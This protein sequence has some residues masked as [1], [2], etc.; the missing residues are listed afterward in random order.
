MS[1]KHKYAMHFFLI[2][3][4][5]FLGA[6]ASEGMV[7]AFFAFCNCNSQFNFSQQAQA[8]LCFFFDQTR[9]ELKDGGGAHRSRKWRNEISY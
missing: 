2:S 4:L 6:P 3:L 1:S 8:F 7:S 5:V 9:S